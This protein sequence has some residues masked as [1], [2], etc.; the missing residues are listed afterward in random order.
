M[1]SLLPGIDLGLDV[2][3][4]L[5]NPLRSYIVAGVVLSLASHLLSVLVLYGLLTVI[6][7]RRQQGNVAFV[8]SVL[9]VMTPAS[10]FYCAPYSEALFSLLNL[11][12]M[13]LYALSKA[14]ATPEGLTL[15]ADAYMLGSGVVFALATLIRSNGLLSG[16]IFLY[17][18]TRYLPRII[19]GELSFWIIRKVAVTCIAGISIALGF[20]F[21]Q[22]LAYKE[23]CGHKAVSPPRP[24]CEKTLPSIYSFVQSHY[25]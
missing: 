8:A 6:L 5:D 18:V 4:S 15:T 20:L 12:G 7:D 22:Y 13:L 10:L 9:H 16:L 23:F 3:S 19:S 11:T 17:D 24:W 21:P 1:S 2:P 25:W 14:S